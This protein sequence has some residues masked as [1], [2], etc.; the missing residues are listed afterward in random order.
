MNSENS[1]S[2]SL[3]LSVWDHRRVSTR[4]TSLINNHSFFFP[5]ANVFW[6]IPKRE[7]KRRAL[8][9]IKHTPTK[10][11]KQLWRSSIP[12]CIIHSVLQAVLQPFPFAR[13]LSLSR[14]S[15]TQLLF[16]AL[17][18]C[19]TLDLPDERG[20]GEQARMG[21]GVELTRSPCPSPIKK[22][23]SKQQQKLKGE[24]R[25][26]STLMRKGYGCW[27]PMLS[28]LAQTSGKGVGAGRTSVWGEESFLQ[29]KMSITRLGVVIVAESKTKSTLFKHEF[30]KKTLN[31]F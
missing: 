7:N 30:K 23:A 10:K 29:P 8:T 9:E 4:A 1:L 12:W 14:R 27:N 21:K 2:L 19:A 11:Q 24:T 5:V 31:W 26:S 15:Q 20:V 28:F 16:T 22:S 6:I 25:G 13:H 3:S 17:G 18:S